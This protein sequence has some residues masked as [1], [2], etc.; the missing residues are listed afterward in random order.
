MSVLETSLVSGVLTL[1]MNRPEKRNA[2][3]LAMMQAMHEALQ[4]AET[5]DATKVVVLTG[6]GAAFCAGGDV[7]GMAEG[8]SFGVHGYER[9]VQALRQR[10]DVARLLHEIGKPTIAKLRGAAAGAGMSLALACD[11]RLASETAQVVTAFAKVGV[12]GDFGGTWFLTRLVGE[13]KA[14]ELYFTSP[15]VGAAEALALGLFNRVLPDGEL[16]AA[17]DALATQIADGPTVALNYMKRT[18]SAVSDGMSLPVLLDLEAARMVRSMQTADHRE[19]AKAF[20]EKRAPRFR[21]E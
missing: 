15:R 19:A 7:G 17:V 8:K 6:A 4:R 3:N 16:D 11:L 20:V 9:D 13:A 10:M 5:D 18:L 1:T 14:K 21:G 12:A 2:M